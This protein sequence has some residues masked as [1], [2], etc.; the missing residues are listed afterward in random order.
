[1]TIGGKNMKIAVIT[2]SGS[3]LNQ[4]FVE[5]HPNL[6]VIP[7]MIVKDGVQFRDQID[8]TAEQIYKEIDEK[9]FSTSLPTMDSLEKA[10]EE[11]KKG[12]YTDVLVIN[13]SSGLSGTF[14]AFRLTLHDVKGINIHQYDTKTLGAGEGYLV[15]LALDLIEAGNK[16]EEIIQALNICRFE[17]SLAI[18]TINTLKYLKKG[19]RIGKV[20]GTIGDLLRIKPV[21]TVN[22][23]GVYVTL[24]KAIGM[25]RSLLNMKEL[26]VKKFG[27][28][29]VDLTVHYG[30]DLEKAT[31]LGSMM[32]KTLNVRNL[33]IS[34]LTPVLGIH[35]G[36]QMFAFVARKI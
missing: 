24:S 34:A 28:S 30:E 29:L 23:E 8:I 7:L 15:E 35:T 10:I 18:Y 17:D 25:Q 5:K 19:G 21:I 1:M 26:M 4:A 2:D 33:N 20:E 13:I 12:G 6:K 31:Q 9:N 14:N 3:N 22:N 32:S 27:D 36:P 16:P 11:V